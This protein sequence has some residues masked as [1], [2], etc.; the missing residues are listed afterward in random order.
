MSITVN[1]Y[2]SGENGNARK[3]AEEMVASGTVDKIRSE[4]GNLR[5]EYFQPLDSPETVLLI[6]S[7][8]DQAAIDLHH[9]SPMMNT[10]VVLR[11]KY[12]LKMRV[13]R[14][15]ADGGIPGSDRKFIVSESPGILDVMM[16]VMEKP[17]MYIGERSLIGLRCFLEGYQELAR[18]ENIDYGKSE[19]D[20]FNE[21]L[22]AKYNVTG[23]VLWD[24]Y[25]T[26][27][28]DDENSAFELFH[29]ELELFMRSESRI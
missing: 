4:K 28:N 15:V 16:K 3:F 14:Y 22:A 19:Y 27:M 5:Y 13:E 6:D 1:I 10:I 7:W 26:E 11:Q 23:S 12:D 17:G 25:L 2:Y 18:S 8:E 21:W 24:R 29:K 20:R 9:A